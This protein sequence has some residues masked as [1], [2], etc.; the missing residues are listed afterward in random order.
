MKKIVIFHWMLAITS[1]VSA[2]DVYVGTTADLTNSL[3]NATSGDTVWI[4]NGTYTCASPVPYLDYSCVT[5][6]YIGDGV[7]VRSISGNPADV[8]LDGN[9]LGRVVA[10]RWYESKTAWIIG[11]TIQ[12]GNGTDAPDGGGIAGGNSS[13]CIVQSNH[14]HGGT[15]GGGAGFCNMYNCLIKDNT[16]DQFGGASVCNLYNCTITGNN[17]NPG[18]GGIGWCNV[19]NCISWG[20]NSGDSFSTGTDSYSCGMVGADPLLPYS[21]TGSIGVDPLFVSTNDFRL[22]ASSPCRDAGTNGLWTV[23]AKDLDGNQRIWP[24]G[25]V[26]DMG[27]YEYGSQTNYPAP[28]PFVVIRARNISLVSASSITNIR[29]RTQ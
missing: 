21:G 6:L 20:N 25:G 8:I 4:S 1:F 27:A 14:S 29:G 5:F 10:M 2:A 26:V 22:Q 9:N 28:I 3:A 12:N 7:T 13:N 17:G 11:C 19:V 15:C 16:A 23:G 18:G 24:Q